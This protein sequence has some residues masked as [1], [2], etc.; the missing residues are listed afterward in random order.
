M[1]IYHS[2]HLSSRVC[3]R[4]FF[5]CCGHTVNAVVFSLSVVAGTAEAGW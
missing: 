3:V 2:G 1:S 4:F 5:G